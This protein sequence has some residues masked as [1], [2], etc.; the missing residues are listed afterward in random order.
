MKMFLT[1]MW[2]KKMPTA[3]PIFN[4]NDIIYLR[5][6]AAL[7]FLEAMKI[8]EVRSNAND[9]AWV[10]G[11]TTKITGARAPSKFGDRINLAPTATMYFTEDELVTVCD[12]LTLSEENLKRQLASIQLQKNSLCP[13]DGT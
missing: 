10:Y 2:M 9:S 7:G 6:S 11:I 5:E 1:R 3:D 12:A 8:G 4:V 13:S